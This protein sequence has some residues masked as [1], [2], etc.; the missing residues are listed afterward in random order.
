MSCLSGG[1]DGRIAQ[2]DFTRLVGIDGI[3]L[4]ARC[5]D[6]AAISDRYLGG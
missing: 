3:G 6:S 4:V 1:D 2:F 5:L